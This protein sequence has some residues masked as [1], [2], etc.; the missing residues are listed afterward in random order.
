MSAFDDYAIS[1]DGEC[2][3]ED[4]DNIDPYGDIIIEDSIE[5]SSNE[6]IN[7]IKFD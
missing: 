6:M 1:I 5:D 7:N 2:F 4:F 3:M